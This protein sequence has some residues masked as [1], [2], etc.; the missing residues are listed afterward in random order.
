MDNAI[1][2]GVYICHCGHNIA[3]VIDIPEVCQYVRRLDHVAVVRDYDYMCSNKGYELITQ[4][5]KQLGIN[6][7]VVAACS[8]RLQEQSFQNALKGAGLNPYLLQIAFSTVPL[9]IDKWGVA[10]LAG[11]SLFAVDEI[12]KALFPRLFSL[13]KWRPLSEKAKRPN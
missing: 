7:V 9:G 12:R 6:R 1:K 10:V 5:I 3:G 8:P 2:V 11:G 13:G 4:D